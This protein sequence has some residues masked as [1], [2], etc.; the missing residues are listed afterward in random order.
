MLPFFIYSLTTERVQG[1]G[2]EV[3]KNEKEMK[4]EKK[5]KYSY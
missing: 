3:K 1:E 2:K 5:Y 4:K